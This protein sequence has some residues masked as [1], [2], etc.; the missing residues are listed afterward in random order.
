MDSDNRKDRLDLSRRQF[1][2]HSAG[3]AGASLGLSA[4]RAA[5][6]SCPGAEVRLGFIGLGDRGRQLLGAAL[7]SENARVTALCDLDPA[8]LKRSLRIAGARE[9]AGGGPQGFTNYRALL[10]SRDVDAVVISTPVHL[11]L[12]QTLAALA[13]GRHV[14]CE[15][16]LGLDVGEC[17]QLRDACREAESRGQLYQCGLQRR[18]NPR[19]RESVRYLQGKEPGK[20]LFVRAQWH[21]VASS[22]K[23]KPWLFRQEKSGGLVLEQGTHQFDVF[24]WIFDSPPLAAVALGGMNNPEASAPL[25]D[26]PDHYG[27]ILE[28][29]GGAKVQLSHMNYSIPERRFSGAYELVFC[30]R[31]GVDVANAL[32]WDTSGKSRELCGIRGNETRLAM[33][34]FLESLLEGKRPEADIE[35]AYRATLSSLLCSRALE[36]EGKISW[37]ELESS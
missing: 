27:A 19:Y 21:G 31:A 12:P 8:K 22:R 17:R 1:L 20:I 34:S 9:D 3:V 2:V 37:D 35:V 15:K 33:A 13:A 10:D 29:P 30:E 6:S 28:Y 4:T 14:Y 7:A 24:N 16:P 18:Y 26:T 36:S 11:H 25:Q 32:V 23:N 5:D